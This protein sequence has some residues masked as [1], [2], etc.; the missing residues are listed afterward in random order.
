MN[1]PHY[2]RCSR[3][4]MDSTADK[5]IFFDSNGHCNFCN[6]YFLRLS[7][8][9][10]Q[11]PSSDAELARIVEKIKNAGKRLEYDCVVGLSGGIDSSYVAYMVNKLGLRAYC[12]HLD[13][14]WDSD[15]SVKNIKRIVDKLGFDYE[16]YVLDWEEFKDLQLSFLRASVPDAETPTDMA[17]PAI[18]YDAAEKHGIKYIIGGGNYVTEGIRPAWWHYDRKDVT[19][20]AAIHKRFGTVPL[21]TFPTFGFQT[22]IFYKMKG[23]KSVYLLN[24]VPYSKAA[25]ME[26]LKNEFQWAYYGGKH[27]ESKYTGFIQ[28]YYLFEKFRIDYR[29]ATFSS[30]ICAGAL[31]RDEA[32]KELAQKPYDDLKI[33]QEKH[34]LC[35]K[36][37]ISSDEFDAIM[38]APPKSYKDYPNNERFL[39]LLYS[40]YRKL[41]GLKRRD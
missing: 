27:Y 41:N 19:Y 10:Y 13:N 5:G 20:L 25:A 29:V 35:K 22:E 3:C 1:D 9:A 17:I 14:G 6:H 40:A 21:R 33:G 31:S 4:V 15:I 8:L 11:G 23:I 24:Y 38:A 39:Q 30:Q 7:K 2:R 28:A 36:L 34:Y 37:G 16:S 18:A 32:L 26:T 12:V